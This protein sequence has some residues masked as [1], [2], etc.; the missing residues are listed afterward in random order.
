MNLSQFMGGASAMR[1]AGI[2]KLHVMMLSE[3]MEIVAS[4]KAMSC[5]DV[6]MA[7]R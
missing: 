6:I 4:M 7:D 1:S 3:V 2:R 5:V